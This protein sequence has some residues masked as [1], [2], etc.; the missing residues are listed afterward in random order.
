MATF[1]LIHGAWGGGWEWHR[2]ARIL[3]THGHEVFTP[4]LTGLGDRAHLARPEVGLD[5]HIEDVLAVLKYE[6]LTDVV[7]SGHS[8]GGMVITGVIDRA[9]ERIAHAV[10]VDGVVPRDGEALL[11]LFSA[12][13]VETVF[14]E[15]A[16]RSGDGWRVPYTLGSEP[17]MAAEDAAWYYP[18]L[19]PHPLRTLEQPIALGESWTSVPAFTYVHFVGNALER[20]RGPFVRRAHAYGWRYRELRGAADAQITDPANVAA[21]L[22]EAATSDA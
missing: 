13:D 16:A 9:P 18:R 3:Q 19:V 20:I 7:L 11:D 2:V 5:T 14:R 12:E 15:P 10:Y 6:D 4:T 22:E 21:L 1:V 17:E 8:Y